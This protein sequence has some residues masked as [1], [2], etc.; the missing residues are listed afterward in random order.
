MAGYRERR[1][2]ED[3]GEYDARYSQWHAHRSDYRENRELERIY[4]DAYRHQEDRLEEERLEK[5][6]A[7]AHRQHG[8]Y[9]LRQQQQEEEFL[10]EAYEQECCAQEESDQECRE[11]EESDA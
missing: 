9:L 10:K 5:Q 7:E 1:K 2:A 4:E 11:Q 8:E 3:Q 6:R